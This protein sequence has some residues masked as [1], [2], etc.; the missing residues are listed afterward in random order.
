MSTHDGGGGEDPLIRDARF[1]FA[2][3]AE[4]D[5]PLDLN[6]MLLTDET[7]SWVVILTAS[8]L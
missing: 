5:T 3:P 8:C 1:V 6:E 7:R 4:I 2:W